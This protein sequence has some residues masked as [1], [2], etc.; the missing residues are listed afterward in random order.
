MPR[1]NRQSGDDK[2]K[3]TSFFF[4]WYSIFVCDVSRYVARTVRP[5]SNERNN[6]RPNNDEK[7]KNSLSAG[8]SRES[9]AICKYWTRAGKQGTRTRVFVCL[10]W[11]RA[12]PYTRTRKRHITDIQY[13][14]GPKRSPRSHILTEKCFSRCISETRVPAWERVWG[15][16]VFVERIAK[17]MY[18]KIP[19]RSF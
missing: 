6:Q 2:R 5:P 17:K 13:V 19:R 7:P 11:P 10:H 9:Q 15:Q 12:R 8:A 4:F 3:E 14:R 1:K 18:I 16:D